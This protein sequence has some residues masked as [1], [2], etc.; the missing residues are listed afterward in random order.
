MTGLAA[1]ESIP[2]PTI[3][4]DVPTPAAVVDLSVVR[5]SVTAM[6]HAMDDA[7][8][9]LRPHAKTHK[10]LEVARLQLDAG[11]SGLTVGTLGEAE[12]FA[13]AGVDD[14]FVAYPVYADAGRG[15]RV[16]DLHERVRL[17][18]G[19]D[20]EEGIA[21]LVRATRGAATPLEV[22]IEVDSGG[23]RTGVATPGD[24]TRLARAIEDGGLRLRGV[25]THGGH[26]YRGDDARAAAARDEVDSLARTR[27]ELDAAGFTA[28]VLSA[29]S[30]PTAELS[31]HAPVTEQ[32]PGTYVFNDAQQVFLGAVPPT[33]V[34]FY[35]VATVVSTAVAGQVIVD[36]GAK[37][38]SRDAHPILPGFGWLADRG[39]PLRTMND[40]HGF[41][42]IPEGS[43][44]PQIGDRVVVVPNHV[45][46]TV[47]LY[48]QLVVVDQGSVVDTWR[49]AARGRN[50]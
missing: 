20:S 18:I 47:N 23:H 4:D 35:V 14:L 43:S 45:C 12:V 49:V 50:S 25:F 17:A 15:K 21:A 2:A 29:G 9:R 28:D 33:A 10:C 48:D 19:V 6:Q 41:V 24:V 16:R 8:V 3:P 40:Y 32:R 30:T 38:V 11:A 1:V 27:D 7:G 42:D 13:D 44:S 36:A 46:P 31:A 26:G 37:A 34:G 22:M 39:L 5:A